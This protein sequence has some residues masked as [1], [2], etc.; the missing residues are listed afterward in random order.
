MI[1]KR[2][3]SGTERLRLLHIPRPPAL[4]RFR[5]QPAFAFLQSLSATHA[6]QTAKALCPRFAPTPRTALPTAGSAHGTARA[7]RDHSGAP[8]QARSA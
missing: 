6:S 4:S 3:S 2:G 8:A 5:E 1:L 7:G